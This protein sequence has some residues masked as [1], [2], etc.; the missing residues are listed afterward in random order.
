MFL[1]WVRATPVWQQTLGTEIE[2]EKLRIDGTCEFKFNDFNKSIH[3]SIHSLLIYLFIWLLFSYSFI[4]I[5]Y[6]FFIFFI[7]SY[8]F[9]IYYQ[10]L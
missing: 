3:L 5:Y 2:V 9:I 10:Y 4:S 1:I 6:S 8:S 7:I